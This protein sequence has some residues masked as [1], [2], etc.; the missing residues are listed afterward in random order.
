MALGLELQTR[1]VE[2][3]AGEAGQFLA[4]ELA[5]GKAAGIEEDIAHVDNEATLGVT[6][7][8][9]GVE[10]LQQAGAQF[11][12]FTGGLFGQQAGLLGG[13]AGHLGALASLISAPP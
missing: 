9:H 2:D 13:L 4:G 12:L 1:V 3:D 6:G 7:V 8:E 5:Q 10:L 11:R